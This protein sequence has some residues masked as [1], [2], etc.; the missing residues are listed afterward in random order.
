[1]EGTKD[2]KPY[3]DITSNKDKKYVIVTNT[4]TVT[5]TVYKKE[6][7]SFI[8]RLFR[9]GAGGALA[10]VA[11]GGLMDIAV[12]TEQQATQE[13]TLT[14]P[15][16]SQTLLN[17]TAGQVIS[18]DGLKFEIIKATS[19]NLTLQQL[20]STSKLIGQPM[21]IP[22]NT[23]SLEITVR[24][25]VVTGYTHFLQGQGLTIHMMHGG[26]TQFLTFAYSAFNGTPSA[27]YLDISTISG[28]LS[29]ASNV[30]WSYL[31]KGIPLFDDTVVAIAAV[32][33][34]IGAVS[35]FFKLRR[36]DSNESAMKKTEEVSIDDEPKRKQ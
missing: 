6:E 12:T 19:N 11:A 16:Q 20:S 24:N 27:T 15:G 18:V 31:P 32:G 33:A 30:V 7:D 36:K 29:G 13:A 35:A 34:A 23:D 17:T 8:R 9:R 3:E 28:K 22:A 1:M 4:K 14:I 2:L 5:K 25:G 26:A 10:G 21:T